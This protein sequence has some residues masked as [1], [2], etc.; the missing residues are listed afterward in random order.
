M[1]RAVSWNGL[2]TWGS[3]KV[4]S[5]LFRPS[6]WANCFD[7]NGVSHWNHLYS[8]CVKLY[9]FTHSAHNSSHSSDLTSD[10]TC[11]DLTNT[12]PLISGF[13]ACMYLLI[14]SRIRNLYTL[15]TT[16]AKFYVHLEAT[17]SC[18]F[19]KV[20]PVSLL[21]MHLI[22]MTLQQMSILQW[23]WEMTPLSSCKAL[24]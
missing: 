9:T 15:C 21:Y 11:Y 10:C 3:D 22:R 12:Y 8:Q 17:M 14:P 24:C 6:F 5:C 20:R 19:H 16:V 4:S 2:L 23:P 13:S 18:L 7:V 1:V